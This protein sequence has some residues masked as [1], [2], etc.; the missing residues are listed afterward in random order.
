M[1]QLAQELSRETVNFAVKTFVV[2]DARDDTQRV[3]NENLEGLD[4]AD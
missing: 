4:G 3:K 1:D 2:S